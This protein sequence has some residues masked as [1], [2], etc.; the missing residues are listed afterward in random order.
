MPY[1]RKLKLFQ[2]TV[3]SLLGANWLSWVHSSRPG[4]VTS[5][6]GIPTIRDW[7]LVEKSARKTKVLVIRVKIRW[8]GLFGCKL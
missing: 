7:A 1:V 3:L 6:E 4:W 2:A 8:V 5:A